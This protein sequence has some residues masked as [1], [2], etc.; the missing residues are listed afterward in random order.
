MPFRRTYLRTSLHK[1]NIIYTHWYSKKHTEKRNLDMTEGPIFSK[2]LTFI[3]PLI[4]T[5]LLQVFYGVA[6]TVIV[7]FS[8]EPDAIGAVGITA[9]LTSLIVNLFIGFSTGTNV[10][11]AKY[12]GEK[13]D[14][15][16]SVVV[17]TSLTISIIFGILCSV[18]GIFASKPLLHL[19]GAEGKLLDLAATYTVIYFL[20]IP[21][22][23]LS[24]YL[25]AIYRAKG[26]TRTPLVILTI[27]G[28]VNVI[29]NFVFVFAFHTSVEGVALATMISNILSAIFLTAHLAKDDGPC[30][31]LFKKIS[32]DNAELKNIINIGLP[33]GIQGS[34]FSISN[35]AIQSAIIQ[36]NNAI[37]PI[38]S[39]FEPV[40]KGHTATNSLDSFIYTSQNT[41]YQAAI[42]FT[43]QNNG[44][45]KYERIPKI[46]RNAY[47]LGPL[48]AMLVSAII[49]IF[50]D[51]LLSLYGVTNG[52]VGSL[53]A[54][55][56][57]TAITHILMVSA[58]YFIFPL[59]EVGCG[60]VRGLG[61]SIPSTIISLIGICLFRV[62]W[63]ATVFK[64]SPTLKTI[65]WSYPI[66]W[67]LTGLVFFVYIIKI[68][69]PLLKQRKQELAAIQ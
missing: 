54:I 27:T 23:S 46:M 15:K 66:S 8:D 34:L 64:M 28:L 33:A 49:V 4:L 59:M 19:I 41:V 26:D 57:D 61:K 60:I 11:V 48:V 14:E 6:D 3:L 31:F 43:S 56:Y 12:L 24:N 38:G 22:I 39:I 21:F 13:N 55:A 35:M 29:L 20:G 69:K 37:T 42:T 44:A 10:M 2:M 51:P 5:N 52:P 32:I 50:R 16:V 63:V 1:Q 65:Y 53:E 67:I 17:H 68:L 18:I 58:P 9:A 7:G 40:V 47:L 45:K 30:K 62:L 36:V 25:I